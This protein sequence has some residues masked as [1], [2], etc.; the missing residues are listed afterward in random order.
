MVIDV[1]QPRNSDYNGI[2]PEDPTGNLFLNSLSDVS[3]TSM[4]EYYV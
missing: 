2:M 1:T 3:S 4:H